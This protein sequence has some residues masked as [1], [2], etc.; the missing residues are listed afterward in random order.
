MYCLFPSHKRQLSI[1]SR[2]LDITGADRRLK[3]FLAGNKPLITDILTC[4]RSIVHLTEK[5][6]THATL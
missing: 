4:Q 3:G 1:L 2:L 6:E 5:E